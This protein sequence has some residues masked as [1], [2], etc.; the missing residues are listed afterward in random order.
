MGALGKRAKVDMGTGQWNMA[1]KIM[2]LSRV[3]I[4]EVSVRY[5]VACTDEAGMIGMDY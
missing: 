2:A 1:D 3:L 5:C 4:S